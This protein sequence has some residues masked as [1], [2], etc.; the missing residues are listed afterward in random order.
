ME[1]SLKKVRVAAA[2]VRREGKF[3]VC[4]R[5]AGGS[6]AHLYEFPGGKIEP[7][8]TPRACA[9]R[10]CREELGI[11]VNCREELWSVSHEY[12]DRTVE[13]VFFRAE[14]APDS[15]EPQKS[16]HDEIAW[17]ASD[18]LKNYQFCPADTGLIRMLEGQREESR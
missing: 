2:V 1:E 17:V 8:E 10:E 14:L 11:F 9:E 6:C 15:P 7:G 13:L 12:P 5:S 16:V 4:K 3:L 18:E